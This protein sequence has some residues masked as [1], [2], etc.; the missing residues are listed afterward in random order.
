MKTTGNH[1]PRTRGRFSPLQPATP[2]FNTKTF[3]KPI[4]Q[5]V[6]GFL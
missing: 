3:S 1:L 5:R 6:S 2:S 4:C